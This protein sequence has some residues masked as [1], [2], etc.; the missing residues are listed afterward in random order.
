MPAQLET[1]AQRAFSLP[2]EPAL[3]AAV[4]EQTETEAAAAQAAQQMLAETAAPHSPGCAT[5]IP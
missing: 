2:E 3:V 4:A 5:E 1:Q